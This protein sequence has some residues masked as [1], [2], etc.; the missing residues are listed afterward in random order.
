MLRVG[1]IGSG[2]AGSA[3][4]RAISALGGHDL[5]GNAP[6]AGESGTGVA[7]VPVALVAV[8]DAD[9][10]A[11]QALADE[12]GVV[13]LRPRAVPPLVDVTVLAVPDDAIAAAAAD[14]S[15]ATVTTATVTTATD[16][17]AIE[18][19][20]SGPPP[21]RIVVHCSGARDEGPLQALADA[22]WVVGCWHPLQAFPTPGTS[23]E[24]GITWAITGGYDVTRVLMTLT[25]AL[26][27]EPLVLPATAKA[28]YHAAATLASNYCVTLMAHAARLLGDVGMSPEAASQ[29]LLALLRTTLSGVAQAGLPGGL[30][31][32][33]V[34]GDF[35]T[36]RSHLD[37]LG[38]RPDTLALYR[39]AG[40]ATVCL[41]ADRGLPPAVVAEA[42]RLMGAEPGPV[43]LSTGRQGGAPGQS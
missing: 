34:R 4:A 7:G 20:R 1:V 39:A 28:R 19:D 6:D 40:R 23:V 14:L 12:L 43:N 11:A 26:G 3:I 16:P 9:G 38:D 21:A 29:A 37:E 10:S 27:G 24:P 30:T 36:V 33:L 18:A 42:A 5:V 8:A 31:G 25:E 35:G 32:P 22:G 2:R 41:L 17:A 13:C 15:T